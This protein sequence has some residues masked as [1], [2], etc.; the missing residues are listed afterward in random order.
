MRV[1]VTGQPYDNFRPWQKKAPFSK[2]GAR[3]RPAAGPR[4]G[5]GGS[6]GESELRRAGARGIG[7]KDARPN[8]V[9]ID[10]EANLALLEPAEKKFPRRAYPVATRARH[11]GGRPAGGLAARIDRRA[12]RDG[13]PGH[14]DPDDALSGRSGPVPHLS[15]EH[16]DAVSR[17]Q[18]HR[19]AGQ[20]QQ[21]RRACCCAIDHANAGCSMRSRRR[22]SRIS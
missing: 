18:L 4:P 13:R 5:D 10:Y 19:A 8:V 6:G 1:N 7:R 16:L 2:R 12:R 14:H 9:V 20:K 3:R 21:A 17:Q 22:S 15:H 11:G